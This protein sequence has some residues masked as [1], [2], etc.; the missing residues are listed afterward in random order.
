MVKMYR[1]SPIIERLLLQWQKTRTVEMLWHAKSGKKASNNKHLHSK[2]FAHRAV[3]VD[4]AS[5]SDVA[6][7]PRWAEPR[8]A[9]ILPV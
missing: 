9:E 2:R 1:L 6:P 5:G 7:L 4:R 8:W 3:D